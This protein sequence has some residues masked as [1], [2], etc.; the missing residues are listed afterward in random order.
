MSRRKWTILAVSIVVLAVGTELAFRYWISSA[1]CVQ[2]VNEGDEPMEDLVL[3]YSGTTVKVGTLASGQSTKAWFSAAGRGQLRLGFSQK[4]NGL[5]GFDFDEF[6]P[7]R[8]RREGSMLVLVVKTNRVERFADTDERL[9]EPRG[10]VD[11][12]MEMWREETQPVR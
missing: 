5:K 6:D 4:G 7:E 10:L 9:G 3:T 1:S 12:F 11:R 2:I 8:N